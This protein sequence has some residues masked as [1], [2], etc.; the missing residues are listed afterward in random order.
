MTFK[1]A[2][3]QMRSNGNMARNL[4][5]A[6]SM[7]RDA[8]SMGAIYVQ[9]P[10]VANVFEPDKERLKAI[11]KTEGEDTSVHGY[12]A[13]AK[14]LG[15]YLHAGSFALKGETGKLANRSLVFA[16]DGKVAARYDK[17]HLFDIDLPSGESHRESATYQPGEFAVTASL[18]F[19]KLGLTICYD[20]RFP[21][22]FNALAKAGA[23]VLT[24]PAAFT[25]PTG[26]AHWH[27]LQQAR[28][29]ETGS[30]VLSAA[31][32]GKHECGR[33]TFGHSI[34]ISPW[35][36]IL[37]EAGTDPGVFMVDIEP[38]KSAATRARIP[39][40]VHARS[41]TLKST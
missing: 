31:Q 27:V 3:I 32:G 4:A 33:S 24:I 21:A 23:N 12:S 6:T 2:L 41:F 25:V 36:E 37:V 28:A 5:D 20:L 14:E 30:F 15:V 40:L 39:A 11:C 16:P 7:I 10:E 35:G 8:A 17:I 18:P 22:L 34:A 19:A 13:L 9:T 38:E 26:E 1:A 29:I